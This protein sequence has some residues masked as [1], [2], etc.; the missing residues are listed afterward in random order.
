MKFIK[1]LDKL[2]LEL[3]SNEY[4]RQEI[5][6]AIVEMKQLISTKYKVA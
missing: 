3:L 2:H 1:V 4:T 6:E 5:A